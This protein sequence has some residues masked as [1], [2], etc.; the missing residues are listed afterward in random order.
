MLDSPE[1][2]IWK[3]GQVI[4]LRAEGGTTGKTRLLKLIAVAAVANGYEV[5]ENYDENELLLAWDD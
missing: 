2:D 3:T 4:K 1:K 5:A